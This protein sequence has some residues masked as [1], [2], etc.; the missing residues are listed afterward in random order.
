MDK[1]YPDNLYYS[2]FAS[3]GLGI[4][5]YLPFII[6]ASFPSVSTRY[7]GPKS[8]TKHSWSNIICHRVLMLILSCG[9]VGI[10]RGFWVLQDALFEGFDTVKELLVLQLSGFILCASLYSS[11]SLLAPPYV[12]PL[13]SIDELW[14][15][16]VI[17]RWDLLTGFRKKQQDG[18]SPTEGKGINSNHLQDG[19]FRKTI[20]QTEGMPGL[21]AAS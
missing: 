14:D 6:L 8:A 17:S 21:N 18:L 1:W 15:T 9:G 13:D 19:E 2:A 12:V 5:I 10:W 7:F 3:M 11:A 20:P 4:G 16:L